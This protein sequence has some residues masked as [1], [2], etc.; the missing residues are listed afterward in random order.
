MNTILHSDPSFQQG[1]SVLGNIPEAW[2]HLYSIIHIMNKTLLLPRVCNTTECS[3]HVQRNLTL[4]NQTPPIQRLSLNVWLMPQKPPESFSK[5][6]LKAVIY[7]D[8]LMCVCLLNFT[9]NGTKVIHSCK[10]HLDNPK[11]STKRVHHFWRIIS[12]SQTSLDFWCEENHRSILSHRSFSSPW[13]DKSKDK[14]FDVQD[15]EQNSKFT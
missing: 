6:N 8:L 7:K 11:I 2:L 15:H 4:L 10:A 13:S 14:L 12:F 3:E 9:V 1:L 5:T